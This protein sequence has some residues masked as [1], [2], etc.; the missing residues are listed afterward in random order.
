VGRGV[1]AEGVE[2]L[3]GRRPA[4]L[5]DDEVELDTRRL[6]E[7]DPDGTVGRLAERGAE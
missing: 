2:Q 6:E 3:V 4:F 7:G 1:P 5:A